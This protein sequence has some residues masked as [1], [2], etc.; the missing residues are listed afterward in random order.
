MN[1][2]ERSEFWGGFSLSRKLSKI[3]FKFSN[4]ISAPGIIWRTLYRWDALSYSRMWEKN[5]TQLWTMFLRKTSSSRVAHWKWRWETRRWTWWRISDS[6]SPPNYP[7]RSIHQRSVQKLPSSISPSPWKDW[8]IRCGLNLFCI[9][10]CCLTHD[11]HSIKPNSKP[12]FYINLVFSEERGN[13]FAP[14]Y[15]ICVI[16][17]LFHSCNKYFLTH[18][19]IFHISSFWV[20]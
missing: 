1:W 18:N 16:E 7:T 15:D 10:I 14:D 2:P 9:C 11:S 3:S 4:Y 6:T 5:W 8:K 20:V 13:R 12:V 17:V 19:L